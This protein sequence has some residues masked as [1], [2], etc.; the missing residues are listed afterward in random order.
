MKDL[1]LKLLPMLMSLVTPEVLKK[2]I[3]ALLDVIETACIGSAN[4]I[5]DAVVLPLCK[6]IRSTLDIPDND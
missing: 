1:L 4:K 3:D 5:D 6:L 2:G